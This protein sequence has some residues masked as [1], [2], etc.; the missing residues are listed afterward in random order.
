M[1]K[2]YGK[3]F[4]LLRQKSKAEGTWDNYH[5]KHKSWI[6]FC[7]IWKLNP[8]KRHPQPIY[9]YFAIWRYETTK[10]KG[11]SISQ[12]LTAVF[13]LYNHNS[14]TDSIN[15]KEFHVL[16]S[17]IKGIK[18]DPER[19]NEP[20]N[21]IRNIMLLKIV[22]KYK[23]F[24]YTNALWK[25]MLCFAKGFALRCGEYTPTTKT[26]TKRT[27]QWKH[28]NFHTYRNKPYLSVTLT[29]TK[30]NKTFKTEILTRQCLCYNKK[31]KSICAVCA[32]KFYKKF[33]KMKFHINKNSYVF[34]NSKGDLVTGGDFRTE[35]KA[36]LKYIGIK[37]PKYPLWRAHS[38][39]HGELTDLIA[40]AIPIALVRKY[41]RHVPNSLATHQ[42][43]QL[44]TDEE[45]KLVAEKYHKHFKNALL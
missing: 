14:M 33:A 9:C 27:L 5:S 41:A 45:A 23:N 34:I 28:L 3:S 15:R 25:A 31:L 26:P 42:Y 36:A 12:D 18:K 2:K 40:A 10:N 35:L 29:I 1:H 21:P 39:R 16:G 20:T 11:S 44:E 43:I 32:M 22:K 37:E 7:N 24:N 17:I 8:F 19:Q 13:S 30:T 4:D 6:K 38:L